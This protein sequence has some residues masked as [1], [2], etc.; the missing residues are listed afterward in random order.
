M[1]RQLIKL[2]ENDK[3]ES[4]RLVYSD[5]KQA[6]ATHIGKEV[7]CNVKTV[8]KKVKVQ[9]GKK[10]EESNATVYVMDRAS[11]SNPTGQGNPTPPAG[12]PADK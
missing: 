8:T 9:R 3:L 2:Y 6:Y 1:Q 11:G 12:T 7:L 10:V 5:G 4:S